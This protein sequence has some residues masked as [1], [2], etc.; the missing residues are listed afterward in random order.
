[1][2]HGYNLLR[3]RAR[4]QKAI[5]LVWQLI[6]TSRSGSGLEVCGSWMHAKISL[7]SYKPDPNGCKQEEI[8]EDLD[9]NRAN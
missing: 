8:E 1:M 3:L 9:L 4:P 2:R 5:D 7:T 6:R